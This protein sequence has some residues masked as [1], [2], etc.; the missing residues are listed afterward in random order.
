ME[1]TRSRVS[2]RVASDPLKSYSNAESRPVSL[3]LQLF[4]C[5]KSLGQVGDSLVSAWS[6]PGAARGLSAEDI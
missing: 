6:G 2:P 5:H 3:Q 1:G 4:C